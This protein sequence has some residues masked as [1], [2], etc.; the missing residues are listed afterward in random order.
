M[1]SLKENV[2]IQK[3]LR[4]RSLQIWNGY[5]LT[6]KTAVFGKQ[7]TACPMESL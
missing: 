5:H 1:T 7:D 3:A 2:P 4:T 6:R